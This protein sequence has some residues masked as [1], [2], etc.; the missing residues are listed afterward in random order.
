MSS[1]LEGTEMQ[2]DN[3]SDTSVAQRFPSGSVAVLGFYGIELRDK[4]MERSYHSLREWTRLTGREFTLAGG[5]G[6][7]YPSRLVRFS[8]FEKTLGVRGFSVLRSLELRDID[9][10]SKD[11]G[12]FWIQ[13]VINRS[14]DDSYGVVAVDESI[15]P[16]S[17]LA[18]SELGRDLIKAVGAQYAIGYSRDRRFGPSLYAS[19]LSQGL[20]SNGAEYEEA[21]R[22]SRWCDIGMP[23]RV[24]NHGLVRD[25]YPFSWLNRSQ[26]DAS[27][28]DSSLEKWIEAGPHRGQLS[29]MQHGLRC[30]RI[31]AGEIEEARRF[32]W[33][34][35]V[36]FDWRRHAQV[37]AEDR[38]G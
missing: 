34:R 7:G 26:L 3:D 32:L 14:V 18:T 10:D 37:G 38:G 35:G 17:D 1:Y 20:A 5:V 13:A 21:L 11:P 36:I 22:I 6:P 23:Q 31:E 29:D 24:F 15:A 2:I 8:S 30:W 28:G 19:G 25:V 16:L 12:Q 27:V 33:D 4:E 9:P